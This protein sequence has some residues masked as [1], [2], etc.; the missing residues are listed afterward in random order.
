LR[1]LITGGAGFIGSHLADK[2]LQLENEVICYDNFDVYYSNKD[3]NVQHNLKNVKYR[4]IKADILD[5]DSLT[6]AMKNVDIV[7]HLAA[8]PGVR[9]SIE[10]PEKA[11]RV[12]ILGTINVLQ[13]VVEQNVKKLIYASSS[14]VY[15]NP[16]YL[17]LD[18]M[19]PTNPI[20]PYGISKLCAEKYC[21]LYSK[22]YHKDIVMLR[23]FTV[24]GPRQ[25][26]DM[27]IH[28]FTRLIVQ[29]KPPQIYGNGLQ[30]RDFTYVDDIVRG[31]ILAAENNNVMGETFNVGSG[32]K[33][34]IN[35]LVNSL[36]EFIGKREIE[37]G[38]SE[39]KMGDVPHTHADIRKAESM[40]GYR[41]KTLLSE[42]L[43]KFY[44]WYLETMG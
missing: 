38:Y 1:I 8:Q 21:K 41:P 44:E 10:N 13:S 42:G 6:K 2:L 24:Y 22:L 4:L 16:E 12:N 32:S 9:F 30:S 34:T 19:H 5:Y 43:E 29:G 23:Y 15:G 26:P 17:P 40:L 39:P 3:V 35:E 14:S 25:R 7:F 36:I 11:V 20:S 28:K 31:T 18:E 33:T 37:P 27:A